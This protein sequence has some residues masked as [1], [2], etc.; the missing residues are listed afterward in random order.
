MLAKMDGFAQERIVYKCTNAAGAIVFS[1]KECAGRAAQ[2]NLKATK[3]EDL[4][5][6]K[7]EH[8][9]RV[10]Q[11]KALA[12]QIQAQRLAEEQA[13][14]AAQDQ[15]M[16]VIKAL[17][18]KFEQERSQRNGAVVSSPNVT[19]SAPTLTTR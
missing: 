18:D 3:D 1:D 15:Q 2:L 13:A 7:A 12:D 19:Q 5:Q 6:Q 10:Q 16:Q 17:A 9:A 14:R 4:S 11:D 8:D